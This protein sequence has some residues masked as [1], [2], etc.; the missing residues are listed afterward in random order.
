MAKK[1]KL[2]FG[3]DDWDSGLD[4]DFDDGFDIPKPPSKKSKPIDH[5][6]D[7]VKSSLKSKFSDSYHIKSMMRKSLPNGFGQAWDTV[8]QLVDDGNQ[9]YDEATKELKPL[10]GSL[11][12]KFDQLVPD[13]AK[14]TK[15]F[16]RSLRE[17]FDEPVDNYGQSQ[18]QS[19]EDQGVQR[20]MAELEE[21]RQQA[22][23]ARNQEARVRDMI[24]SRVG[25]KRFAANQR[26]LGVVANDIRALRQ[27]NTGFDVAYKKKS[28]ELQFRSYAATAAMLKSMNEFQNHSLKFQNALLLNTS[29][30][31]YAKTTNTQRWKQVS[32]EQFFGGINSSLFSGKSR[33][34]LAGDRL[35]KLA[36]EKI[37]GG[38]DILEMIN[39]AVEMAIDSKEMGKE[40]AEME[41]KEY[42]GFKTL[43]DFLGSIGGDMISD[44]ASDKLKKLIQKN[45]KLMKM[46]FKAGK[47]GT[48]PGAGR[49]GNRHS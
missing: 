19:I 11:S 3:R 6:A 49:S 30:P 9:L 8:D 18:Q 33:V 37:T 13:S 15:D 12:R 1:D 20:L 41:G 16:A 28:L 43:G 42:S 10:L 35:K 39:D 36:R 40:M 47:Y 27:Y 14:R 23:E 46:S 7:G 38:K 2:D 44:F 21:G 17:K 22:D 26:L 24:D 32:K 4:F 34:G 48:N 45:P 29:L 5:I 31:E 25:G